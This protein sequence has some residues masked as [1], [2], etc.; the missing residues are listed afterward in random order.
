MKQFLFL[1]FIVILTSCTEQA[2][3][4]PVTVVAPESAATRVGSGDS[5]ILMQLE[6]DW[7]KGLVNRD[8]TLFNKLL[9]A[10]FFYTENDKMYTRAEVIQASLAD[11]VQRAYNEDMQ[12]HLFGNTGIVT[13][14][15]FINGKTAGA[16]FKRKYRFTDIWLLKNDSWKLVAAQDYL[17][18]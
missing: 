3:T 15:L 7:A 12:V 1:V 14:W 10:D 2:P 17:L 9:A 16:D 18:P 8:T 11:T 6:N 4:V 13:G 5:A